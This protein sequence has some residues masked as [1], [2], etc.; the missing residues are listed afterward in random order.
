MYVEQ[1][2]ALYEEVKGSVRRV[3]K[4]WGYHG[5]Y[6]RERIVWLRGREGVEREASWGSDWD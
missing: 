2:E 6:G 1:D 5:S 4:K 3:V